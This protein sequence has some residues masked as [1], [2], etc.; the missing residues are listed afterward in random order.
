VLPTTTISARTR[1]ATN[2]ILPAVDAWTRQSSIGFTFSTT[3]AGGRVSKSWVSGADVHSPEMD[4]MRQRL[5]FHKRFYGT[6]RKQVNGAIVQDSKI[7]AA[8]L[9]ADKGDPEREGASPDSLPEDRSE[10][11]EQWR[12][13]L[14][15]EGTA[16]GP[17]A[18]LSSSPARK[19]AIGP[20]VN[21]GSGRVLLDEAI[22][23]EEAKRRFADELRAELRALGCHILDR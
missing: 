1:S 11:S 5:A 21:W 18:E 22:A 6:P 23:R 13:F 8:P 15:G 14:A 7:G 12:S 3:R 20:P 16:P 4:A 10:S 17:E 2:P 19:T 9:A